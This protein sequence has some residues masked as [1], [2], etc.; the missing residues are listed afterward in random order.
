MRTEESETKANED[1]KSSNNPETQ[2]FA[3]ET[4]L[5]ASEPG[6]H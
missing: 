1:R 4:D 6:A 5:D 2:E 3:A